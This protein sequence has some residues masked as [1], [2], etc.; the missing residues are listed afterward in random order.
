MSHLTADDYRQAA[1]ILNMHRDGITVDA[2]TGRTWNRNGTCYLVAERQPI[3]TFDVSDTGLV[4]TLAAYLDTYALDNGGNFDAFG[5]YIMSDGRTVVIDAVVAYP[6]SCSLREILRI[7]RDAHQEAVG[8]MI[9][10]QYAG[11]IRV[12]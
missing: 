5:S 9:H 2:M 12:I 8:V 7:A 1:A 10:G 11:S 4:D 6:D 3:F